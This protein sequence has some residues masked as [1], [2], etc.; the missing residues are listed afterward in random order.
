MVI[1]TNVAKKYSTARSELSRSPG[2]NAS[3]ACL[4]YGSKFIGAS[5]VKLGL[6]AENCT[7][8]W[9]VSHL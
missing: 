4:W 2:L 3:N 5:G 9:A 6:G 1:W 7:I 8:C